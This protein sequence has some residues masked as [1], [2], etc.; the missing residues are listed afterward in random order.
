MTNLAKLHSA[1]INVLA[2]G[3]AK[4]LAISLEYLRQEFNIYPNSTKQP[5]YTSRLRMFTERAMGTFEGRNEKV[6]DLEEQLKGFPPSVKEMIQGSMINPKIRLEAVRRCLE[7]VAK[8]ILITCAN[9]IANAYNILDPKAPAT[10]PISGRGAH[11][12]SP[13]AAAGRRGGQPLRM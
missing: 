2:S 6:N 5:L 7:V 4:S 1:Q 3:M 10:G 12:T 9:V 11:G 13:T 8:R